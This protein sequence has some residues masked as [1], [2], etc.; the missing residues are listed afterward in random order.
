MNWHLGTFAGIAVRVHAT[1]LLLLVFV[2]WQH[3]LQGRS[4][5][6]VVEGVSFILAL[7]VCVVL[8]EFGHAL[9][10]K[11][12]GI[13]TKDITILPIGG[14]ARLDRMPD[15]PLQ[16]LWVALAGP[17]VNV[18]IAVAL[19]AWL[20][21]T[22]GL[23]PLTSVEVARG[24]FVER[25]M[26]VN[27]GLVAF[28]MLPAFPMDGGRVVRALLATR[29]EYTRATQIAATLGQ[30]MAFLFGFLGLTGSPML[31]FIA[32]FV[33]LGATQEA[34]VVQMRSA[35][36]GIPVRRAM[37]TD[38]QSVEPGDPLSRVVDLLLSGT[39]QD[40]PVVVNGHLVG[41]VLGKDIAAALR[42]HGHDGRVDG[43]M[44]RNVPVVDSHDMLEHAFRRLQGAGARV[45]AVEHDGELLGLVSLDNVG[46]F[47]MVQSSLAQHVRR[48]PSH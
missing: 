21:A 39:Q 8:H 24:P 34:S 20:V 42:Q 16:E 12:F 6:A 2:G 38:Y 26:L 4:A 27:V 47:L 10:A 11:R 1:F 25:L 35:L 18:V 13:A 45:G 17:A 30:T 36:A 32:L 3:W 7:F 44:Q 37:M 43:V 28:N 46:E 14:V 23:V 9:T 29:L 19:Y 40:F 22:S 31:L 41:I 33:W 5:Q 48:P 15:Q